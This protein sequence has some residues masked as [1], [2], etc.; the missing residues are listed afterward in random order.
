MGAVGSYRFA[1]NRT[2]LPAR[3]ELLEIV[4]LDSGYEI[5]IAEKP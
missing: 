1:R 5:R 3:L 4:H 2:A